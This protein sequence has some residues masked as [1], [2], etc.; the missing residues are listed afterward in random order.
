[1]GVQTR[2]DI[3]PHGKQQEE[4]YASRSTA[5]P[6]NGTNGTCSNMNEDYS[7]PRE[8]FSKNE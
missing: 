3:V 5:M 1:M 7:M 4:F 8:F 2:L 6:A